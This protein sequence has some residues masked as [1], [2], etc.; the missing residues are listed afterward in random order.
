[1][2]PK[3]PGLSFVVTSRQGGR[4]SQN[5]QEKTFKKTQE[6]VRKARKFLKTLEKVGVEIP[7]GILKKLDRL[8]V[9]LDAGVDVADA[10]KEASVALGEYEASLMT[11]CKKMGEDDALICE[12]KV[13]RKWQALNVRFVLA[14]EESSSVVSK[15]IRKTVV[16]YTPKAICARFDYCSQESKKAGKA[17]PGRAPPSSVRID[18]P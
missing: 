8:Q 12:A 16:R 3:A 14:I 9:A 10:A 15:A 17:E 7:R 13:A 18:R 4:M 11:A 1:M 2:T 5:D 6:D